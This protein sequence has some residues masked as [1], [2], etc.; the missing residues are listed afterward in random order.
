M[1]R[2]PLADHPV[3]AEWHP[4][5]NGTL[6]P[7]DLSQGSGRKVWW[8]CINVGPEG[9]CRSP[10]CLTVHEWKASPKNRVRGGGCHF[11]SMSTV[12][13]YRCRSLGYLYP[14]I[15]QELVSEEDPFAIAAK[16]GRTFSW[17]C[18]LVPEGVCPNEGCGTHH[19]W[20]ASPADRVSGGS[21]C[22]YCSPKNNGLVICRCRSLG[23]LH[24]AIGQELMGVDPFTVSPRSNR[25]LT[26]RCRAVPGG[27]CP[28]E[29]CSTEHIWS[30]TSS[31]RCSGRGCPFCSGHGAVVCRCRTLGFQ[32][33][34]I[35]EE[36]DGVDPFTISAQS[37]RVLQWRCKSGHMWLDAV[38]QRVKGSKCSTCRPR[39][40]HD[41]GSLG[42]SHPELAKEMVDVDPFTIASRS[43]RVVKWR[44]SKVT[45][46]VCP[47]EG[48][49][50][51]HEWEAM[52]CERTG[53]GSG[54]PYCAPSNQGKVICR[55]RSLGFT[56][57]DLAKELVDE[58][59][60]TVAPKSARLLTWRCSAVPNGVCPMKGC[61]TE[62]IWEATPSY[63]SVNGCPFCS[64]H[65]VC[66]CRSLGFQRPDLAQ[67]AVDTNPYT[68]SVSSGQY[69]KWRCERV[70]GGVCPNDR[71][72]TRHE[73]EAIVANR[74]KGR[75]C[76]FCAGRSGFICRCKSL[77]YLF[78]DIA[79]EAVDA[80]VYSVFASSS[81]RLLWK[82]AKGHQWP[83]AVYSRTGPGRSC[84]PVCNVNKAEKE[85][86]EV[87]RR[88][89]LV[90]TTVTQQVIHC[91]DHANG[92]RT[93]RLKMDCF[94]KTR[95]GHRCMIE[96]DGPQHFGV[97]SWIARFDWR[98]QVCR[99]LAKNLAAAND[100]Y[101]IL[102]ISYQE[103]GEI[104]LW[105]NKFLDAVARSEP[106][107]PV[108]MISNVQMY[109]QLK[110]HSEG[111]L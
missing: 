2:A 41:Y 18:R 46:G 49:G 34:E 105:V 39:H 38:Y 86:E 110:K 55:C 53:K 33:P 31:K 59:A 92:G 94:V 28:V 77:G 61:G 22:P 64:G 6:R 29:G 81:V 83:T 78:P 108:Y 54:C 16:S 10:N 74:V 60:F 89:P 87:C 95:S 7:S 43:G 4:T 51:V 100:G 85:L 35:A 107:C 26:W 84:C 24:P 19:E 63:R 75:G 67:Q 90:V 82:C 27:V 40:L 104:E 13:T 52:P 65:M 73:W 15:A 32:Y 44:C 66:R 69:I 109:S 101:C 14:E 25:D 21:G 71:C 79:K 96:L 36:L 80:D 91:V 111:L 11:C 1:T 106:T 5:K 42:A 76:P 68:I 57:P 97:V 70:P 102:R 12:V 99:D 103:Y 58:D 3:A 62:H 8:I 72:G 17:T 20:K 50:T 93:R 56:R 9:V 30:T 23:A 98:D 48:C 45:G 88:H 47:V 37:N